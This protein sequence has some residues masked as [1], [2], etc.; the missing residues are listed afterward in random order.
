MWDPG[1]VGTGPPCPRATVPTVA[2]GPARAVSHPAP[3]AL[4][5]QLVPQRE[6]G[7]VKSPHLAQ[8]REL[9]QGVG[10]GGAAGAMKPPPRLRLASPALPSTNA[11]APACGTPRLPPR[12][13]GQNHVGDPL[14]LDKRVE[15]A[16][17]IRYVRTRP[18]GL[19]FRVATSRE[20][21]VP[22]LPQETYYYIR[23]KSGGADS[24]MIVA[25]QFQPRP[26]ALGPAIDPVRTG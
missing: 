24:P 17:S 10:G 15:S 26:S 16:I 13:G 8:P 14:R 5:G 1:P 4:P 7:G 21:R 19:K 11:S 25:A 9:P 20:E 22:T 6:S 3:R 2:V 23:R 18:Q 12:R